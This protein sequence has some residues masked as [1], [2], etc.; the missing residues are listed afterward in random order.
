[1]SVWTSSPVVGASAVNQAWTLDF[2]SGLLV[3]KNR[4]TTKH[5]QLL[6][7]VAD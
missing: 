5:A 6:V 1:M 7:R 4:T 3:A 2:T